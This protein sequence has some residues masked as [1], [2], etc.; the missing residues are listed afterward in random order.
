MSGRR[1]V[2]TSPA[3]GSDPAPQGAV[4]AVA[5]EDDPRSWGNAGD[6]AG[7]DSND[8]QLQR[9][10]PPHWHAGDDG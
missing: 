6:G 2:R 9:D 4:P 3:A 8:E 1:R 7:E 10:V 5:A